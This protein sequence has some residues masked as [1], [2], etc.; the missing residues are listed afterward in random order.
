MKASDWVQVVEHWIEVPKVCYKR[1]LGTPS[2]HSS[3]LRLWTNGQSQCQDP[4]SV[5]KVVA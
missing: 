5:L 4:R 3:S 1:D 2:L